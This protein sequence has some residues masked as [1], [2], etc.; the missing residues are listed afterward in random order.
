MSGGMLFI[1]P[2][3]G[4]GQR[5]PREVLELDTSWSL[6]RAPRAVEARLFWY[7]VGRG[8]P[9]SV[10][11]S[12]KPLIRPGRPGGLTGEKR[13]KFTLPDGPCSYLGK[14]LELHWAVEVVVD[15]SSGI[16]RW[17]FTMGPEGKEIILGDRNA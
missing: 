16:A 17:E 2:A 3:S 15:S 5:L 7:T 10:I 9:D 13:I 12:R 14:L 6:P 4:G 8:I 11:V 1:I